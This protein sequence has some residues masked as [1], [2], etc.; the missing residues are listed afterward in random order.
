M[1]EQPTVQITWAVSCSDGSE[2]THKYGFAIPD[3]KV[4]ELVGQHVTEILARVYQ[5]FTG[6]ILPLALENPHVAYNPTYIIK[7]QMG[8][9]GPDDIKETLS[10][11]TEKIKMGFV[12]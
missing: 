10:A 6:K 9:L 7:I 11:A 4:V 8:I 5:T 2:T 3:P 1:A 12:K